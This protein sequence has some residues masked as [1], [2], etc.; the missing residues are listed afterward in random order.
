MNSPSSN[1]RFSIVFGL[2]QCVVV[3]ALIWFVIKLHV[4]WDLERVAG[5]ALMLIGLAGVAVARFQLG[6]SFS[7]TPQARKLVTHGIYSRVRNPIY[8][9]GTLLVAGLILALHRPALWIVLAILV[10]AQTLRA[11]REARV[12]E[13]TFGDEYRAYRSRTWF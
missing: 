9:F 6:A 7:V 1:A 4:S 5:A 13:D 12:L 10:A 2:V 3:V 8:V 11:H